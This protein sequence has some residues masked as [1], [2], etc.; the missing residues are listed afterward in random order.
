MGLVRF[1]LDFI[2]VNYIGRKAE[3]MSQKAMM[4]LFRILLHL[5]LTF[6]APSTESFNG[7]RQKRA[8]MPTVKR[9]GNNI[10]T[11]G[12][13]VSCEC[14]SVACTP[15]IPSGAFK[16][17]EITSAQ[18]N[19]L[20]AGGTASCNFLMTGTS[21]F[22]RFSVCYTVTV[23][24]TSGAGI[25]F[26][27]SPNLCNRLGS[28]GGEQPSSVITPTGSGSGSV[29][30]KRTP[31]S[32]SST[33]TFSKSAFGFM[34]YAIYNSGGIYP[35]GIIIQLSFQGII[36]YDV[37]SSGLQTSA[38]AEIVRGTTNSFPSNSQVVLQLQSGNITVPTRDVVS[39][40]TFETSTASWTTEPTP[41]TFSPAAP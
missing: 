34:E 4:V 38:S 36:E 18:F 21:T 39:Q 12:G 11:K 41:I 16:N 22:D 13:K 7:F 1:F 37:A 32:P 33:R 15:I 29:F 2:L 26:T 35:F 6:L 24:G 30:I 20:Y 40:F 14:C 27:M 17:I 23:N 28:F 8:D 3:L 5:A 9:N 25:E 19:E 31:C 10:I